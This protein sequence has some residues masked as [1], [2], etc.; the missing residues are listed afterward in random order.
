MEEVAGI[1]LGF[2]VRLLHERLQEISR[3]ESQ[4]LLVDLVPVGEQVVR[5]RVP[6]AE[7]QVPDWAERIVLILNL[8]SPRSYPSSSR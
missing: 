6:E 1:G 8:F 7:T 4:L 2:W 3:P 5:D